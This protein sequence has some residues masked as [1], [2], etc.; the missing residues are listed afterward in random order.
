M[1]QTEIPTVQPSVPQA[2]PAVSRS[3]M[4]AATPN[5]PTAAP[6]NVLERW[7]VR[8]QQPAATADESVDAGGAVQDSFGQTISQRD[9]QVRPDSTP[10]PQFQNGILTAVNNQELPTSPTPTAA[11]GGNIPEQTAGESK[12]SGIIAAILCMI[13]VIAVGIAIYS[14]W[15]RL[16]VQIFK[17]KQIAEERN[18]EVQQL[19]AQVTGCQ[20]EQQLSQASLPIY[21]EPHGYYSFYKDIPSL[22]VT[23]DAAG[24]RLFYGETNGEEPISGFV[25]II[26]A[27]ETNGRALETIVNADYEHAPNGITYA[28]LRDEKIAEHFGYSYVAYQNSQETRHYYLQDS[29]PSIRYVKVSYKIGAATDSEYDYYNRMAIRVMSMLQLYELD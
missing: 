4:V 5:I 29:A 19:R 2:A 1:T 15:A 12:T 25:M 23:A 9:Q 17:Y 6:G 24:A 22:K 27:V 20:E 26:E 16:N 13:M 21:V 28:G 14:L 10:L 3:Q 8:M 11:P 7:Q 18:Q